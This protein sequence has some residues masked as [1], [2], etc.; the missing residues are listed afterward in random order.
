ML[1]PI[2]HPL[3]QSDRT[4]VLMMFPDN[5]MLTPIGHPL[6]QSDIRHSRYGP[7]RTPPALRPHRATTQR[8]REH[9][10]DAPAPLNRVCVCARVLS[11]CL[12]MCVC[13]CT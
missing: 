2:G 10:A 12:C 13:V 1:T 11:V 7:Q 6:P 5:V 8:A 4:P 3:P 9:P